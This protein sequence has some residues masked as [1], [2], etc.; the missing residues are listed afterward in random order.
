MFGPQAGAVDEMRAAHVEA[1][2]IHQVGEGFLAAGD[3]LGEC[4]RGVIARLHDHAL[5]QVLTFTRELTWMNVS[6]AC[7]RP[8]R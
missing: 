3:M 8:F 2:V 7:A 1:R 6:R 4:H 5:E